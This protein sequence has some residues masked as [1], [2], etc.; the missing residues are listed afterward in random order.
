MALPAIRVEKLSKL[1]RIGTRQ[2][3]RRT[4]RETISD[5]V[6]APFRHLASRNGKPAAPAHA[7][8]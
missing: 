2:T 3:G 4:L 5:T 8:E 7:A 6:A 1:Y